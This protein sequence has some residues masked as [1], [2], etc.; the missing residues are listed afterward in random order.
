[1]DAHELIIEQDQLIDKMKKD[2]YKAFDK[3]YEKY[4]GQTYSFAHH[5]LK[6][7]NLTTKTVTK[8]FIKVWKERHSTKVLSLD[9]YVFSLT[10][11]EIEKTLLHSAGELWCP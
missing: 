3:V 4:F 8:V 11:R 1:M 9:K 10:C 7:E 5:I 2:D 6:N